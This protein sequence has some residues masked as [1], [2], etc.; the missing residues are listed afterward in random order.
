MTIDEAR[1]EADATPHAALPSSVFDRRRLVASAAA[2]AVGVSTGCVTGAGSSKDATMTR[3]PIEIVKAF[4][5]AMAIKDYDA[6]LKHVSADCEY[7]N[8]PMSSVRGPEGMRSVLEPFFAPTLENQLIV[9]REAA[10]GPLVFLERL[11]RHRL[12]TGWVELPVTGVYEVHDG[13]ITVY[14]DYF[15]LATI[16]SKWPT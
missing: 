7:T 4:N 16:R 10:V 1:K 12:A 13:L 3:T 9:I 14:R 11:D 5:A 15:D 6:A 8:I 2:I